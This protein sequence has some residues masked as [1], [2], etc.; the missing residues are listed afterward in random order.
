MAAASARRAS[1]FARVD[2]MLAKIEPI[3]EMTIS[4]RAHTPRRAD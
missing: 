3:G 4:A 1:R 2:T